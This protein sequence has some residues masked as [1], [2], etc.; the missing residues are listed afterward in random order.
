MS[1][2][3][4]DVGF[5][6]TEVALFAA[7]AAALAGAQVGVV[8]PITVLARQHHDTFHRRFP[9]FRWIGRVYDTT[10]LSKD[11]HGFSARPKAA[12]ILRNVTSRAFSSVML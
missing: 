9:R 7:A 11:T 12:M 3:V 10:S 1:R 6:K 5:G 2:L 4:V 8:A